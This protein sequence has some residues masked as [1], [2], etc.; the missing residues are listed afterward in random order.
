MAKSG[1]A[2]NLYAVTGPFSSNTHSPAFFLSN[3]ERQF[4]TTLATAMEVVSTSYLLIPFKPAPT[5]EVGETTKPLN[6]RSLNLV[7]NRL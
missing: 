7:V 5:F 3:D 4:D 6:T 2:R 1:R